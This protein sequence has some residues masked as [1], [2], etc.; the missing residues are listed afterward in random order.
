MKELFTL[1]NLQVSDFIPI[2]EQSNENNKCEL[3]LILEE[4]GSIRLKDSAPLN[5]MYG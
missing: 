1:G 3:N 4:T 2:T 5:L